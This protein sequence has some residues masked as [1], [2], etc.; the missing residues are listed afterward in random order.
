[1]LFFV[2]VTN[3]IL[4]KYMKYSKESS[5]F[6][7]IV[8]IVN[9]CRYNDIYKWHKDVVKYQYSQASIY[10]LMWAITSIPAKHFRKCF[11]KC[12]WSLNCWKHVEHWNCRLTPHSYLKCRIRLFLFRYL[13]PHSFGHTQRISD[14]KNKICLLMS[15]LSKLKNKLYLIVIGSNKQY[16]STK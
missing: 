1:M 4:L 8:F 13:R 10:V 15:H 14:N 5:H 3:T 12:P 7:R 2:L 9:I 6:I 11:F 16:S